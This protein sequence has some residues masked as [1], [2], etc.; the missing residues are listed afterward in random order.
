MFWYEEEVK[1]VEKES[2]RCAYVPEVIFYGSSS[3]RQWDSLYKDFREHKPLNL[4][5]GGST[6]A[7]CVWYFDRIMAPLDKARSMIIYAGDNDLGDGRHPEEVFI[8]FRQLV[9]QVREKFG[10]IP[11]GFI[12]IKPSFSRWHIID[13]IRFT[14]KVIEEEVNRKK[15]NLY[16]I[17]VYDAMTDKNGLPIHKF[18]GADGLHLSGEG[19]ALWEEILLTQYSFIL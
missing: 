3:I 13:R 14:N 12:S 8:S 10:N 11:I 1:R 9:V 15:D 6:L 7:A 18:F 5:F 17:N 4:G 16:F 2:G 19:Y